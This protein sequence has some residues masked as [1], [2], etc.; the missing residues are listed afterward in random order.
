MKKITV[1]KMIESSNIAPELIRAVIKQSGGLEEF[2]K[3]ARD[4]GRQIDGGFPGWTYYKDTVAF[5]QRNKRHIMAM[6][7]NDAKNMREGALEMLL[8]FG[9]M[10]PLDI[11]MN[12]LASIIYSGQDKDD[13]KATVYNCLAWYAAESVARL[14]DDLMNEEND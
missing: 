12:D 5:A 8:K 4:I 3:S 6:A 10:K 1:K 9:C 13:M 14:C 2:R 7:E 11:A